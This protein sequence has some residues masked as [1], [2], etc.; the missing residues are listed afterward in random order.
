MAKNKSIIHEFM[1][2]NP[3]DTFQFL[4]P[5]Q[6]KVEYKVN[7]SRKKVKRKKWKIYYLNIRWLESF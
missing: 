1:V 7:T 4:F 3:D 5:L 2:N 6:K